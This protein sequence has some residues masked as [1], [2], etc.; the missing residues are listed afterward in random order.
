MLPVAVTGVGSLAIPVVAVFS[1]MWLLGEQ[2][3]GV[4]F[5]ALALVV[6]AIGAVAIPERKA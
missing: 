5:A 1:S 4:E 6:A 2:P 3:G